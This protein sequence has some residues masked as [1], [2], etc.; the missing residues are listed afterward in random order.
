MPGSPLS[1]SEQG[2]TLSVPPL[3]NTEPA[4]MALTEAYE[5]TAQLLGIRSGGVHEQ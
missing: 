1:P 4:V 3:M 2:Q 5:M